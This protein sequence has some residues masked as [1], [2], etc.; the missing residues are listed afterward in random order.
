V[1]AE[2][3]DKIRFAAVAFRGGT[4]MRF[5]IDPKHLSEIQKLVRERQKYG[6]LVPKDAE[7]MLPLIREAMKNRPSQQHL[8]AMREQARWASEAA[9][10]I[11]PATLRALN[12]ASSAA[13]VLDNARVLQSVLGPDGLAAANLLTNRRVSDRLRASSSEEAENREDRAKGISAEDLHRVENL[14]ASPEVRELLEGVDAESLIEEAEG[15][16]EE[17]GLPDIDVEEDGEVEL[18][19][20]SFDTSNLLATAIVL[21][22]ALQVASD[23]APE[24]VEAL[25]QALD[26]IA[27]LIAILI[28]GRELVAA[29]GPLRRTDRE[30]YPLA[31]RLIDELLAQDPDYDR[32]TW[33][34]VAAAID[35]DRPSDRKLFAT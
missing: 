4:I 16:L 11:D 5:P 10:A 3:H 6:S 15:V 9:R 25:R 20:V 27:D 7:R 2:D 13:A 17:E 29:S 12:Q 18:Y 26:T 1:T 33:P 35:R 24:Q 22:A 8:A 19:G 21:Y 32:E 23:V 31:A 30:S 28:A 34:E 14:A